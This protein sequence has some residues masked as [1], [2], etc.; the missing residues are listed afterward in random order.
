VNLA[1][2]PRR[3]PRRTELALDVSPLLALHEIDGAFEERRGVDV[4]PLGHLEACGGQQGI[5][6]AAR[7]DPLAQAVREPWRTAH[8]AGGL[9][10]EPIILRLAQGRCDRCARTEPVV[11]AL[12]ARAASRRGES[13]LEPGA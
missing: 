3:V 11:V 5:R 6:T 8:G 10:D 1:P 7:R 9:A 13:L 4:G 2:P 12:S